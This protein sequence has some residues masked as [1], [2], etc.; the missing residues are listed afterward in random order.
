MQ[1][2]TDEL[3]QLE[4]LDGT[5]LFDVPGAPRPVEDTPAPPRLMA[6]WDSIL[7]AYDDRSRVIRRPT[8]ST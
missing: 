8:A 3:E 7:L 4:G 2:L 1:A 6:M 5:V